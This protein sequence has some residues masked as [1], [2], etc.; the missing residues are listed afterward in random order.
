MRSPL[1]ASPGMP[2]ITATRAPRSTNSAIVS[3]P[4]CP[5]ATLSVPMYVVISTPTASAGSLPTGESML[6][7]GVPSGMC[8]SAWTRLVRLIGLT[9]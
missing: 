8:A 2:A 4:S 7:I 1:D 6:T 3:A 9:T 5:A